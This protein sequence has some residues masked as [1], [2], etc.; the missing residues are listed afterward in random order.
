MRTMNVGASLL[1]RRDF[2]RACALLGLGGAMA[3]LSRGAAGQAAAEPG[4]VVING[5]VLPAAYFRTAKA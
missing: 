3:G 1:A 2:L 5:W 4:F